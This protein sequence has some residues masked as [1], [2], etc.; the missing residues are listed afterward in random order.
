MNS[1][2]LRHKIVIIAPGSGRCSVAAVEA[3]PLR[4]VRGV[5]RL[6]L[7]LLFAC[8]TCSRSSNALFVIPTKGGICYATHRR[9]ERSGNGGETF[10]QSATG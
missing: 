1:L 6:Y 5:S 4:G 9:F 2:T 8:Y 7:N 10:E 3:L